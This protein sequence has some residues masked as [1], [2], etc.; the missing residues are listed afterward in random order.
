M[1]ILA[2][3]LMLISAFGPVFLSQTKIQDRQHIW[4]L[5]D[6]SESMYAQEGG[7][8]RIENA[9]KQM[10]KISEQLKG[11]S[12]GLILFSSAPIVQVPLTT[13]F[14]VF[15]DL[16]S[17]VFAGQIQGKGTN[18]RKAIN[19]VADR[20]EM[21]ETEG[22]KVVI[23][24]DGDDYGENFQSSVERLK[25]INT[26]LIW[27]AC[28]EIHPS[29]PKNVPLHEKNIQRWSKLSESIYFYNTQENLISEVTQIL[30]G[31]STQ[32]SLAM[33]QENNYFRLP[34]FLAFVLILGTCFLT[35]VI[36]H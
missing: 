29:N 14:Q 12:L 21:T 28:G 22:A 3:S 13:D 20:L 30:Q 31:G 24:T 11:A 33:L 16:S 19:L 23:F 36:K 18:L 15:K 4:F 8:S 7:S 26:Q 10:L 35:P 6:I 9:K 27:I 32:T 17:L 25:N 1:R 2:I 5:L 34:L